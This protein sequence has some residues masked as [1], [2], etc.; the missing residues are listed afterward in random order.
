VPD[1]IHILQQTTADQDAVLEA[2]APKFEVLPEKL[3]WGKILLIP[4]ETDLHSLLA[5]TI[6]IDGQPVIF[7]GA[8]YTAEQKQQ[9]SGNYVPPATTQATQ[10]TI[11]N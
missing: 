6:K 5:V 3:I 4:P 8:Y 11:A 9:M 1:Q 2:F 7:E 10:P